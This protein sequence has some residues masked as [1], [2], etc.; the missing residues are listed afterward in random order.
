MRFNANR[1]ARLA[2]LPGGTSARRRSLNE[3]GNRSR[4]DEGYDDGYDWYRKQLAEG[5]K[6]DDDAE[7]LWEEDAGE[8]PFA[9]G[10]HGDGDDAGLWEEDGPV[11]GDDDPEG[12][13]EAEEDP[14]GLWEAEED[15]EGL[16]ERE[17][18]K[19]EAEKDAKDAKEEAEQLKEHARRLYRAGRLNEAKAAAKEAMMTEAEAESLKKEVAALKK[20]IAKMK[21]EVHHMGEKDDM[22]DMHHQMEASEDETKAVDDLDEMVYIN[23]SMLRQEI[24][25]MKRARTGQARQSQSLQ[26]RQL[27]DAIRKEIQNIAADSRLNS[28]RDW[29]YGDNKPR[30]SRK[31]YVARGGF[32]IGFE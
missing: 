2:G 10:E 31:G 3:A 22:T 23:E 15:P 21:G 26:E 13:W 12:L 27:R 24:A 20:E 28:T 11:E 25:R 14:E 5:D 30:N 32:G 9:E 6:G 16:W 17:E 8:N 7:G 19:N 4:D 1:L 29:L 18:E